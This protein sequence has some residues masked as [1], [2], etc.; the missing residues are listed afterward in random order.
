[1]SA[2]PSFFLAPERPLRRSEELGQQEAAEDTAT[3]GDQERLTARRCLCLR[4]VSGHL[5]RSAGRDVD[6]VAKGLGASWDD[7]VIVVMP[8][9]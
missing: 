3:R 7:K 8:I 4:E 1:M 2:R 5:Q 9:F 6:L